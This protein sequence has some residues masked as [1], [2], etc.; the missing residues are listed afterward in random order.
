MC[1]SREGRK[2]L[3]REA[4]RMDLRT[5]GREVSTINRKGPERPGESSAAKGVTEV[6]GGENL[7]QEEASLGTNGMKGQ[8]G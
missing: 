5:R 6:K 7:K 8:A 2:D 3:H 1:Q 4:R